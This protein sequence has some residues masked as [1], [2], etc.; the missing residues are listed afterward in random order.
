MEKMTFEEYREI[1]KKYEKL[2]RNVEFEDERLKEIK[3]ILVFHNFYKKILKK[4]I[5][6][7]KSLV[8][9]VDILCEPLKAP[10]IEQYMKFLNELDL[11][12]FNAKFYDTYFNYY[13]EFINE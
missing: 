11:E 12:E 9:S 2:M 5:D 4:E 8:E 6:P 3:E 10:T 7:E 1:A 13:D